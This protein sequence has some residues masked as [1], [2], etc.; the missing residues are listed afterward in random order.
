M[1]VC[2]L[3]NQISN[4]HSVTIRLKPILH[5]DAKP[6]ALGPDLGLGPPTPQFCFTYTNMLVSKNAQIRLTKSVEYRFYF[7]HTPDVIPLKLCT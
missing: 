5:C 1:Y 2:D 7:V 6:L 4:V 3:F